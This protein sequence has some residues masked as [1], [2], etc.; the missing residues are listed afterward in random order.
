MKG[1][2]KVRRRMREKH[3]EYV[4]WLEKNYPEE[5]EK[6]GQLREKKPGLYHRK[7][8]LSWKRHRRI[9][10]EENP[11]VADVL[12]E[13]LELKKQRRKLLAGLKKTTDKN[14]TKDLSKQLEEIVSRRFDLIIKQKQLRYE[15]LSAKLEKLKVQVK[16][17][18]AELQKD[19]GKKDQEVKSR[20]KELLEKTEEF[21]WD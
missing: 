11:K 4:K 5:A 19:I 1:M 9:M 21:K 20:L 13:D 17:K 7:C 18:E 14:K 10:E 3:Q 8:A 6:L 16:Q 2:D 15:Q 12:K